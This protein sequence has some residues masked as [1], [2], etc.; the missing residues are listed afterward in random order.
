MNTVFVTS[1]LCSLSGYSGTLEI[2]FSSPLHRLHSLS[3][4]D[5]SYIIINHSIL[6]YFEAEEWPKDLLRF[7]GQKK[8]KD[9]L[10]TRV[11]TEPIVTPEGYIIQGQN[12]RISNKARTSKQ[13]CQESEEGG[14]SKF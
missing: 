1:I 5:R 7:K 12:I 10:P 9:D 4:G 3:A 11:T 13:C 2:L 8:S 6:Y 14:C